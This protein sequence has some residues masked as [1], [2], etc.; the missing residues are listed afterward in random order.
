MAR[1]HALKGQTN[2]NRPFKDRSLVGRKLTPWCGV[3]KKEL[4]EQKD[5]QTAK[6]AD[7]ITALL[8]D[9]EFAIQI[10]DGKAGASP[11]LSEEPVLCTV[12]R[13]EDLP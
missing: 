11:G 9:L 10:D 12:F 13:D 6:D 4:S 3:L 5:W 7:R 2:A 1:H 8:H